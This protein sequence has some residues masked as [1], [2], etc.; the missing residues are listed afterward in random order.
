MYVQEK[1]N[2]KDKFNHELAEKDKKIRF[3]QNTTENLMRLMEKMKQEREETNEVALLGF[4][5]CTS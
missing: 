5:S 3:L 4:S 1:K 2:L